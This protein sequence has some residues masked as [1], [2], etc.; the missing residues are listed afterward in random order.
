MSMHVFDSRRHF[1]HHV[2][3]PQQDH[4][5]VPVTLTGPQQGS[6]IENETRNPLSMCQGSARLL[7]A[8]SPK[9]K[10]QFRLA[11]A[12]VEMQAESCQGRAYRNQ[13]GIHLLLEPPRTVV[14]YKGSGVVDVCGFVGRSFTNMSN[15]ACMATLIMMSA[16]GC[17]LASCLSHKMRRENLLRLPQTTACA[18][19][20][21]SQPSAGGHQASGEP[22]HRPTT[23][24]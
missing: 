21:I 18:S 11:S 17:H 4:S 24:K 14:S 23:S 16:S 5:Q 20:P 2:F 10:H 9:H 1:L 15:A 8:P 6:I 7:R 19:P 22:N 3:C 12:H 13:R